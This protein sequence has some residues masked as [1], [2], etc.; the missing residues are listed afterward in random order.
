ML[1]NDDEELVNNQVDHNHHLDHRHDVH[2]IYL[3][4]MI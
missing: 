2:H 4:I 3:K 1:S